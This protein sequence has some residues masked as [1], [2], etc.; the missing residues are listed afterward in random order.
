MAQGPFSQR[1]LSIL[2]RAIPASYFSIACLAFWNNFLRT[3]K[4]T[5]LFWMVSEGVVV[6]LLVFRRPSQSVSRRPWDWIAG[7]AGSF[8][9]LLVRPMGE[10]PIADAAG[11]ALQL[12]GTGFQLYGKV[13]LGRS[14]GIVAANRGVVSS[15]PYRL[16]RH[17]IYLGYLVTHAG[18]L[19]SNP[20]VR[21]VAIYAAAYVFQ[22]ARIYAE[23]RILAKDGE[24]REYLRNVL[25]RLIP[26]VY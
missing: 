19:L 15:G 20:S 22:F 6:I 12:F 10:A 8:F 4:W 24:Y 13:A 21:N 14:F 2:S 11:F 18:F 3:G 1:V 7:F 17:P 9:V 16:I 25:Y 5:S 23:E 26:G